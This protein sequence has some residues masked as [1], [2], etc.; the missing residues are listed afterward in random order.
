M[1]PPKEALPDE[2]NWVFPQI[3]GQPTGWANIPPEEVL[4]TFHLITYL[5]EQLAACN[6]VRSNPTTPAPAR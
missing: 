3:D 2:R 4:A 1:K 6:A 5:T